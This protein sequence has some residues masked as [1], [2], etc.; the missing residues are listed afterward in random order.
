ML[1]ICKLFI[2]GIFHVAV[3]AGKWPLQN[4]ICPHHNFETHECF[5]M[6]QENSTCTAVS[7]EINN[8]TIGTCR[9]TIKSEMKSCTIYKC[10]KRFCCDGYSRNVDGDCVKET[11]KLSSKQCENCGTLLPNGLCECSEQFAGKYCETPICK[12]KCLNGGECQIFNKV[13]ICICPSTM[14]SGPQCETIT[15]ADSCLNGG[16]C[17]ND[18]MLAHCECLFG[19]Q[20]NRCQF[21]VDRHRNCPTMADS[22]NPSL[23]ESHK[24]ECEEDQDCSNNINGK[25]SCCY[26]GCSSVCAHPVLQTCT[27]QGRMYQ[28]GEIFSPSS[29]ERCVCQISGAVKC[30]NVSYH[31]YCT[32]G[33]TPIFYQDQCCTVC[34]GQEITEME[35]PKIKNCP[36]S[37]VTINVSKD[38]DIAE[39]PN[40]DL[41]TEGAS[42]SSISVMYSDHSFVHSKSSDIVNNLHIV[43]AISPCNSRGRRAA[44]R[45]T[46]IVRDFIPPVFK[47]CPTNIY[48]KSNEKICWVE[49]KVSDNVGVLRMQ[50][51]GDEVLGQTLAEGAYR[52]SYTAFDFDQ[53]QAICTFLIMVNDAFIES[54]AANWH[55]QQQFQTA[56]IVGLGVGFALLLVIYVIVRGRRIQ[57]CT[58][59]TALEQRQQVTNVFTIFNNSQSNINLADTKLTNL[60]YY[61][62]SRDPPTY[63]EIQYVNSKPE[64]YTEM[65]IYEEIQNM[66]PSRQHSHD[67][68]NVVTGGINNHNYVNDK[69]ALCHLKI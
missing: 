10:S 31:Q 36:V 2:V 57:L 38:S 54:M 25:T 4:V 56:T 55:E 1:N 18:G 21:A 13:P 50:V 29:C 67:Y 30:M 58:N 43:T 48:A 26:D 22:N 65:P 53:N 3:Y 40:L 59:N 64:E 62:L 42:G 5:E 45:F 28:A 7:V 60:P 6:I 15:C 12:P 51:D 33:Q 69:T 32:G 37:Y 8:C 24:R 16:K 39:L 17:I 34:Q 46:V 68:A 35:E 20:G 47:T 11:D 63:E 19:Y 9:L 27:Y 49:P 66:L 41:V 23:C 52:V 44:C 61:N 14:Y